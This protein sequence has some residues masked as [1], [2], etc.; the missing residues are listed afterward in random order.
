MITQGKSQQFSD[1]FHSIEAQV[2]QLAIKIAEQKALAN[3]IAIE[4]NLPAIETQRTMNQLTAADQACNELASRIALSH[5][6]AQKAGEPIRADFPWDCP[7]KAQVTTAPAL[8][9]VNE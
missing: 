4:A 1:G 5:T 7:D 9:V 6:A 3:E 8:F 2:R